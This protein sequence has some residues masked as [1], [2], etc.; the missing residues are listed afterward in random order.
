MR[1]GPPE[2]DQDLAIQRASEYLRRDVT[3]VEERWNSR[4]YCWEYII[5]VD[6]IE[7]RALCF[8]SALKD[9]HWQLHGRSGESPWRTPA[10]RT[11]AR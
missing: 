3:S 4:Y 1:K 11:Q 8:L 9:A 7:G 10:R 6:G 5:H 2:F